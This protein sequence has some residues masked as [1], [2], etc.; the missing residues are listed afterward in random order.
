MREPFGQLSVGSEFE[1]AGRTFIKMDDFNARTKVSRGKESFLFFKRDLVTTKQTTKI[2]HTDDLSNK[3]H[4]DLMNQFNQVMIDAYN[5]F[6]PKKIYRTLRE[7]VIKTR[8]MNP[9]VPLE[10]SVYRLSFDMNFS[11]FDKSNRVQMSVV[12]FVTYHELTDWKYQL[13]SFNLVID[14]NLKDA[15]VYTMSLEISFKDDSL[16]I[17][18]DF[19]S[20]IRCDD[21]TN[22]LAN[23]AFKDICKNGDTITIAFNRFSQS[24]LMSNIDLEGFITVPWT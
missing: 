20:E 23:D 17:K 10:S 6:A 13:P 18:K 4:P 3:F 21:F 22:Y 9:Q 24:D 1:Y 7:I 16:T 14:R 15:I 11:S 8:C 2:S 12:H 19:P 5:D